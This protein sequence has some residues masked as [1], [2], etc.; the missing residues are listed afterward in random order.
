MVDDS[1]LCEACRAARVGAARA[2]LAEGAS[3][4]ETSSS[5]A[6]PLVLACESNRYELISLLLTATA[7]ANQQAYSGVS[8]LFT[9]ASRNNPEVIRLLCAHGARADGVGNGYYTP[10]L[11]CIKQKDG[12]AVAKALL[13]AGA[14]PNYHSEQWGT[15][16]HAAA[17]AGRPAILKLLVAARADLGSMHHG[18]TPLELAE[19]RGAIDSVQVRRAAP[20]WLLRLTDHRAALAHASSAHLPPPPQS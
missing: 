11:A 20:I 7:D 4:N 1:A 14:D 19:T 17:S 12:A 5:G 8:P 13:E 9:A 16:L 15:P 2:L 6:T 3:P 10:M 18:Q